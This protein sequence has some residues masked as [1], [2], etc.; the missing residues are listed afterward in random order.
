MKQAETRAMAFRAGTPAFR[1][2][3]G[4]RRPAGRGAK[5][6]LAAAALLLLFAIAGCARVGPPRPPFR[7]IPPP[8]EQLAA[9]Q[10]GPALQLTFALPARNIDGSPIHGHRALEVFG[11]LIPPGVDVR[12]TIGWGE[13]IATLDAAGLQAVTRENRVAL[14]LDVQRK[15]GENADGRAAFAVRFSNEKGHWS[16]WT[17]L[18]FTVVARPLAA[19][20]A[21]RAEAV[22]GGVKV[23][24]A[25]SDAAAPGDGYVVFRKELPSGD[26]VEA[27]SVGPDAS[28]ALD[29]ECRPG[30][31]YWYFVAGF[32]RV[33]GQR[34]LG[35]FPSPVEVDTRDVFPPDVPTAPSVVEEDG[36]LRIIWNPSPDPDVTGYLVF[37]SAEDGAWAQ[38]TGETVAASS[39]VDPEADPARRWKYRVMAVDGRGNRS[40]PSVAADWEGR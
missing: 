26:M 17:P 24:W 25:A 28:E 19:P 18:L 23:A 1:Q 34:V 14:L 12:D 10:A 29:A 8:P 37:R 11:G 6:R 7:R 33:A 38:A 5:R 30:L 36:R 27:V 39:W 9:V 15:L 35:A 40:E 21:V 16:A 31:R 3:G 22:K 20:P 2:P 32:R 4:P 13:V